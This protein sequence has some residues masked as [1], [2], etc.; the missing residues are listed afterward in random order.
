M[1]LTDALRRAAHLHPDAITTI[2]PGRRKTFRQL[3]SRVS[4]L[5]NALIGLG[6][7]NGD[8]VAIA[9][10]HSDRVLETQYAIAWAGGI[11]AHADP[12]LAFDGL[13]ALINDSQATILVLDDRYAAQSEAL[14]DHC[15]YIRAMVF[16]GDGPCPELAKVHDAL[17]VAADPMRDRDIGGDATAAL[18]YHRSDDGRWLGSQLSHHSLCFASL[19]LAAEGGFSAAG[20]GLQAITATAAENLVFS[21]SLLLRGSAQLFVDPDR[22]L[23]GAIGEHAVSDLLLTA[24]ALQTLLIEAA[25]AVPRASLG[26]VLIVRST[27]DLQFGPGLSGAAPALAAR[28][29]AA[30]LMT[31]WGTPELCGIATLQPLPVSAAAAAVGQP[32]A[33]LE[34][35][36]AADDGREASRGAF[37]ELYARGPT[38]LRGYWQQPDASAVVRQQDWVACGVRAAV[39]A[40]GGLLIDPAPLAIEAA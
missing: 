28:Y 36:V 35:R 24:A 2:G 38:T 18:C 3:E 29:P 32:I 39:T 5:A 23:G 7:A 22:G 31:A 19:A 34:L 27:L 17:I 10:A 1:K 9:A 16:C 6:L 33:Y 13:C 20:T 26:Q 14:F 30:R 25:D 21:G 11:A 4:C 37:G 12:R 15:T 40:D 8:V